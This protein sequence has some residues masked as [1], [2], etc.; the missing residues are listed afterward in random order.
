MRR[1][2]AL[3]FFTC[4][5]AWAQDTPLP[6][7]EK[8]AIEYK[9]IPEALAG[10]RAKPGTE[11]SNQ[12]GWTIAIEPDTKVIWSFAPESHPAYPALV[13]RA[14]VSQ[15]G[16]VFVKMDVKCQASKSACDALVREF[17]QLNEKMRS[18]FQSK[19][20]KQE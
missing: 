2:V 3:T 19:E 20:N 1:L 17:I 10:L 4:V 6:E 16:S 13:K 14:V 18:S 11:I 7:T 12:G 5:S 8:S 9:S 15:N